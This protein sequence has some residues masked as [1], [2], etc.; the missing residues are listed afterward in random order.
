M[1]ETLAFLTLKAAK[2]LGPRKTKLLVQA[3]GSASNVLAADTV[4]LSQVEGVGPN[5]IAAIQEAKSSSFPEKEW[6]RVENLKLS[7][8]H[9]LDPGYPEALRAIYDPPSLLYVKGSLPAYE[10]MQPRSLGVVGTRDASDF[11]LAFTEHLSEEL[12][13]RQVV[14]NSGLALGVDTA[15]HKGALKTGA[16]VAV[17]GSGVDFIYPAQNRTLAGQIVERGG[18]IISEYAIGSRP[19]ATNFPGRN[20]IIN[21]L[22]SGIV[23]VE[24]G[25]K[26]G[27]L[28]TADYAL[29]EGR[30][31]CAVPGRPGDARASGCHKLLKQGALLVDNVTDILDEFNWHDQTN[32]TAQNLPDLNSFESRVFEHIQKQEPSLDQLV[33]NLNEPVSSLLPVLTMLE[34]KGLIKMQANGRYMSLMHR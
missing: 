5:L 6:A 17:L 32:L 9:L 10:G 24:A 30:Q 16:T 33:D 11:A 15:A 14:I 28:I 7:L 21:G 20:R 25:E 3:F 29:Q 22:S 19:T 34:L 18:A 12:A 1:Q 2:G 13:S 23:V 26:S 4:A 31:V 8:L 27:A